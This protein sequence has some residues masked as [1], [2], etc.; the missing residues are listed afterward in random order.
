MRSA[1]PAAAVMADRGVKQAISRR[2][3]PFERMVEDAR[4][5]AVWIGMREWEK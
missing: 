1:P 5:L 2:G 3:M 4:D